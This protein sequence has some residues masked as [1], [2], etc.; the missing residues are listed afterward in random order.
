MPGSTATRASAA[1]LVP[2]ALLLVLIGLAVSPS[3]AG[4]E[5]ANLLAAL[6]RGGHVLVFRHGATHPHQADTEPLNLSNVKEQRHLNDRGR[7]V[8]KTIGARL[9]ALGVP[10]TEVY[11]SKFRRAVETAELMGVGTVTTTLDLTEGGLVVSPI[12]NTR[13][14]EAFRALCGKELPAGSNRLIVSHKP[15]IV[16]AFGKDWFDIQEGEASVFRVDA[17]KCA[18]VARIR[19]EEWEKWGQ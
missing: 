14:A 18:L 6:K 12:E 1:R 16:D 4:G 11:S 15:N 13:R 3:A 17:G 2:I 7:A 9:A 10:V 5:P 8:A 19:A